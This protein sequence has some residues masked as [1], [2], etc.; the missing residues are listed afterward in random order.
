MFDYWGHRY[1]K[2]AKAVILDWDNPNWE[3]NVRTAMSKVYRYY[4]NKIPCFNG[5]V[6][7]IL[8]IFELED[9]LSNKFLPIDSEPILYK[10]FDIPKVVESEEDAINLIKYIVF[11]ERVRLSFIADGKDGFN[12]SS[13]SQQCLI[14]TEYIEIFCAKANIPCKRYCCSTNLSEGKFHSFCIVDLP[15]GDGSVKHYLVDCTYRQFFTYRNSFLERIGVVGFSGCCMGRYMMMDNSRIKT[16]TSLLKNGFIEMTPENIKNYFDGFIFQ[17]RNGDYYSKLGK[18][19]LDKD[20][21]NVSYEFTD[22][23]D[24]IT[25]R[26]V[27]SSDSM[28]ILNNKISN[29]DMVFDYELLSNTK[30]SRLSTRIYNR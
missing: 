5:N 26:K 4:K 3:D 1:I 2:E 17:G 15:L 8:K 22:Y 19:F 28:N 6:K 10:N 29:P 24:A 18:D 14:S 27:L 21:Y 20:D 23:I 7:E 16:A 12:R 9:L 13:L 11:N 30:N 25:G